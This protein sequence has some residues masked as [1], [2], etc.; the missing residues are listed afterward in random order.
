[1]KYWVQNGVNAIKGAEFFSSS[2]YS[3]FKS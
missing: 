1:V 3:K 2:L